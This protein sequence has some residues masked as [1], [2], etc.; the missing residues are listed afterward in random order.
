MLRVATAAS[1]EAVALQDGDRFRPLPAVVKVGP[2]RDRG[3]AMLHRGQRSLRSW[4]RAMRMAVIDETT[5]TS[6]DP[7]RGTLRDV[8]EPTDL[9][10]T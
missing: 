1:V 10:A 6:L 2:G 4:L 3:A 5:W 9:G 8:D 7:E